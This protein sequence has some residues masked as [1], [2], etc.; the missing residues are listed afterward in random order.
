MMLLVNLIAVILFVFIIWWFWLSTPRTEKTTDEV[1]DVIVDNG[2]YTPS[3]IE[4]NQNQ[5]LKL[6]FIR[7]DASPCAE[8]V[9]FEDLNLSADLPVDQP[10][11]IEIPTADKGEYTF[12]CQMQMYRG[13]LIIN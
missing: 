8:K 6:R 9:I 10:I 4:V 13:S 12:T 2:V 7:K 5:A 11:E 1:I 3:R